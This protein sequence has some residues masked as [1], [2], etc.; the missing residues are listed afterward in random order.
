MSSV[1]E[2]VPKNLKHKPHP[3]GG[4]FCFIRDFRA[5]PSKKEKGARKEGAAFGKMPEAPWGS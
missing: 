1:F 2:N 5:E 4:M 3:I